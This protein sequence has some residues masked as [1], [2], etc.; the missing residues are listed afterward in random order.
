MPIFC[1]FPKLNIR[2]KPRVDVINKFNLIDS[3]R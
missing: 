3:I 2:P 1:L